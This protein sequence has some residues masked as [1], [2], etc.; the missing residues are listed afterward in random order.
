MIKTAL[1]IGRFQPFHN[2]HADALAQIFA[3]G[4]ERVIIG[5]GSAEDNFL[6][7][8]PYTAGERFEMIE[9]ALTELNIPREKYIII[10]IRNI[11]HYALWP[12]HVRQLCPPFQRVYSGSLLVEEIWKNA[13]IQDVSFGK[14]ALRLEVSATRV[15]EKLKKGEDISSLVPKSVANWCSSHNISE[16]LV[17]IG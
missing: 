13:D 12:H 17:A 9:E 7:E 1:Y 15:R 6:P 10:P 5:I 16:R 3:D 14:L 11:N 2:G 4:V 8:N